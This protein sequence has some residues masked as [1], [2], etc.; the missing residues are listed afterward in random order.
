M[1]SSSELIG[2]GTAKLTIEIPV[3]DLQREYQNAARRIAQRQKIPGFRPG[4]APPRVVE[5]LFGEA[6]IKLDAIE[7][8]VPRTFDR[9]L[10]EQNLEMADQP[11]FEYPDTGEG[12][13]D[14][15]RTFTYSGTVPLVPTVTLGNARTIS[16]RRRS[17]EVGEEEIAQ[18]LE[19]IRSSR[20]EMVDIEDSERELGGED[21]ARFDFH[22]RVD[23]EDRIEREG[24]AVSMS[25]P[26]FADGFADQVL[27]MRIGDEKEFELAYSDSSPI[28][29]VAG[30]SA[31]Y[32]VKLVGLTERTLPELNDEFAASVS[33]VES[34]EELREQMREQMS[35]YR[36]R[37]DRSRLQNEALA[38][39]IDKSDF[40]IAERLVHNQAHQLL[41]ARV[42]DLT[43]RGMALETFLAQR[44]MDD[45]SFHQQ[46][47]EDA[48]DMIRNSLTIREF[49]S[50]REIEVGPQDV[51]TR[52]TEMFASYPEGEQE[53]LRNHYLNQMGIES[54]TGQILQERVLDQL[55][56]EVNVQD[57]LGAE[58]EHSGSEAPTDDPDSDQSEAAGGG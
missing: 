49:A 38:A 18:Q 24:L 30:K 58:G 56:E 16:L 42:A 32:R 41:N 4:K 6:A 28:A 8:L 7:R 21:I 3:E 17:I 34:V 23:G 25:N 46:A 9:A 53:A 14:F 51:E 12:E 31:E 47:H 43:R 22:E 29:A 45:E 57:P 40:T 26:G 11:E 37:E 1:P 10:A 52:L 27:G 48:E 13:L 39:L 5:R 20:A 2:D 36:E 50:A 44:G 33:E 15:S 55:L 54:L 19:A 35:D